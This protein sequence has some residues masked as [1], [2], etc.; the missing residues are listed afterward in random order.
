MVYIR[1]DDPK[2]II[3]FQP[4]FAR[5]YGYNI[6]F[7]RGTV[8]NRVQARASI[9]YAG[10]FMDNYNIFHLT[11]HDVYINQME[12]DDHSYRLA[13]ACSKAFYPLVLIC[14]ASGKIIGLLYEQIKERWRR[15][16]PLI[17]REFGGE[18]AERYIKVVE[19]SIN[20]PQKIIDII[21]KNLFFHT[22]FMPRYALRTDMDREVEVTIPLIPFQDSLLGT[23]IQRYVVTDENERKLYCKGAVTDER[24][25]NY[26]QILRTRKDEGEGI[27][28]G[29]VEVEYDV[30]EDGLIDGVTFDA[31][32]SKE[33]GEPLLDVKMVA[34]YLPEY[35]LL[36]IE[37]DDIL[38]LEEKIR[39]E[40]KA[41]EKAKKRRKSLW[42]RFMDYLEEPL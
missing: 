17:V 3:R 28:T 29:E 27:I 37:D 14:D 10:K 36:I 16:K 8:V 40:Q 4:K 35:P 2:T 9:V 31:N 20:D 19:R 21:S 5:E 32:L 24:I 30:S 42:E 26:E 11:G 6:Y 15:E 1:E 34:Y 22:F 7:T 23:G 39:K 12:P 18:Y 38:L 13:Q 25:F 41:E 33:N